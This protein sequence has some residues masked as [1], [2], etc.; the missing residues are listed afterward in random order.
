MNIKIRKRHL[1]LMEAVPNSKVFKIKPKDDAPRFRFSE[2]GSASY[3]NLENSGVDKSKVVSG[4]D[5][6]YKY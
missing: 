6:I 5:K 1:V 3:L 2:F 4:I